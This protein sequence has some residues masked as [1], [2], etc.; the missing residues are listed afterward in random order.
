M[1]ISLAAFDATHLPEAWGL[2]IHPSDKRNLTGTCQNFMI[3][4]FMIVRLYLNI[5]M[6]YLE[7]F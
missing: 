1:F 7:H 6:T 2:V 3:Y 5:I 4:I